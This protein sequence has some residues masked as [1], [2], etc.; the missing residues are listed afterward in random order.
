[1]QRQLKIFGYGSILPLVT[2]LLWGSISYSGYVQP[3]F[4]P[5]PTAVLKTLK[6]EMTTGHLWGHIAV[7][8]FRATIGFFLAVIVAYPIGAFMGINKIFANIIEPFNDI[9]RYMPVPAF[10]P[11]LILWFGVGLTTQIAVIFIGTVLQLTIMVQVAFANVQKEYLETGKSLSFNRIEMLR[12]VYIPASLPNV[13]DSLRI[14]VGWAW[15]YLILAEIVGASRGLGFMIVEA[16]RFLKTPKVIAGI[17][18]IGSIGLLTD[19]LLRKLK[20]YI[21]PWTNVHQQTG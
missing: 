5:T 2:L 3:F 7:S 21:L 12:S 16:Q 11:L 20:K 10:I 9:V 13:Y 1:M 4:I 6:I 15:S 14:T 19:I 17:I 8:C 18:I